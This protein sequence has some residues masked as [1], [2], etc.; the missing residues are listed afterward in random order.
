[1]G[2]LSKFPSE[3]IGCNNGVDSGVGVRGYRGLSI[4]F[5]DVVW[6]KPRR[7]EPFDD[8]LSHIS[9]RLGLARLFRRN[10]LLIVDNIWLFSSVSE[11]T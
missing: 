2:D 3:S 6:S 8:L 10:L 11:S 9:L 1:M 7:G 5:V 4:L